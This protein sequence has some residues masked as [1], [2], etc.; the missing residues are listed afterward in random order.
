MNAEFNRVL[1]LP[2]VRERLGAAGFDIVGGPPERMKL[3]IARDME[4][5]TRVV[6]AAQIKAE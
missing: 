6:K 4:K 2:H 1:L 5:W 3:Q